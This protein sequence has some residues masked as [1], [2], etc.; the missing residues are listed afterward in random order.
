MNF[1]I[2]KRHKALKIAIALAVLLLAIAIVVFAVV[3]SDSSEDKTGKSAN[4]GASQVSSEQT[5]IENNDDELVNDN[6]F[7]SS[8]TDNTNSNKTESED[9]KPN[10]K[11][12]NT[13][14]NTENKDNKTETVNLRPEKVVKKYSFS[15]NYEEPKC[16]TEVYKDNINGINLPYQMYLPQN[17]DASKKYPVVIFLHSAGEI[18]TEN[19]V[20]AQIAKRMYKYNGDLVSQAFVLCPQSY[21]WWNIGGTLDSVVHLLDEIKAKY[22][23]DSDRIYVTGISM[24]GC[25]TWDLLAEYGDIFAAG[26]PMCGWGDPNTAEAIKDIPIRVYHGTADQTV[27]ISRSQEMY[28]AVTNAGG[29]KIEFFK[30]EG[31]G[32]SLTEY[33]FYNRDAFSWLFAQNKSKNKSGDYEYKPFFKVVDAKGNI[34]I[35]DFDIDY[36]YQSSGYEGEEYITT[37]YIHLTTDG[38]AKLT[39]AYASAS[40]EF[41][42]YWNEQKLYS[43][44]STKA[45][46]D[47]E[48]IIA[49][50]LDD[51]RDT[52]FQNTI[53]ASCAEIKKMN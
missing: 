13:D 21:E 17:Y 42:V 43:F 46:I 1:E 29:K 28:D 11:G 52:D 26:M 48:F 44:K 25:G 2:F 15:C 6:N 38:K 35:S 31:M 50:I 36:L 37:S 7:D 23:C 9:G 27:S 41:T 34:V 14:K 30:L 32:H 16:V 33:V 49:G 5:A 19:N 20:P 53:Q 10:D 12:D 47:D 40:K 39:K 18:G 24:G 45:P 3:F 51:E 22:S 8:K 4:N